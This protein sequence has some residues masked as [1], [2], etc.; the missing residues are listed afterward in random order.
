MRVDGAAHQEVSA[1][2]AAGGI[3]QGLVDP[4]L[5]QAR[6]A[7]QMEIVQQIRDDIARRGD[8]V[9]VPGRAIAVD[10]GRSAAIGEKGCGQPHVG[11]V[12]EGR[13]RN[14]PAIPQIAVGDIGPVGQHRNAVRHELDMAELLGRDARDQAVEGAQLLLAAKIEALEHVVP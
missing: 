4:Q 13:A 5:V 8:E 7:F 9:V 3:G 11:H 6:S 1:D 14:V 10:W 2:L 12:G